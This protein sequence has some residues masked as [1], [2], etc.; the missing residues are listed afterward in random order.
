[1][2][3]L[4]PLSFN[5]HVREDMKKGVYVEGLQEEIVSNNKDMAN[6]MAKGASNRKVGATS[7]NSSSSRSHSVLTTQIESK[8]MTPGGIWQ[9]KSSRFHIIDLAGSERSKQT[10]AV[11]ERLKEAG[12]INKSLSALGIVINSLVEITEGKQ[13][14]VHYRDSKLTFLLRDSLGGNSKTLIV[15]NIS[16][17]TI[18]FGETMSTL[19][20]A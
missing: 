17:S 20:F 9:M 10:N 2:D 7:M 5:L 13:R 12:M 11:G 14:H 15:A 18:C 6:I 4:E 19:N 16:P 3:L 1:M 8:T